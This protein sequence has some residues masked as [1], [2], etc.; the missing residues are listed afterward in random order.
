MLNP[1]P[2]PSRS[3]ITLTLTPATLFPAAGVVKGMLV[4]MRTGELHGVDLALCDAYR[5]SKD[6]QAAHLKPGQYTQL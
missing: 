4:Q 2:N 6:V 1:N 3:P 5:W